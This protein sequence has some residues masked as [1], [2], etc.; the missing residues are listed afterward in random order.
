M[1]T[2]QIRLSVKQLVQHAPSHIDLTS[3]AVKSRSPVLLLSQQEKKLKKS[4]FIDEISVCNQMQG[5]VKSSSW[6]FARH[7]VPTAHFIVPSS[8]H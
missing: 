2:P 8:L 6:S 1:P 4:G 3:P 7:A 5:A